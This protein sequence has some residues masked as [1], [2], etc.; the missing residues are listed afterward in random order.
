MM[1][2]DVKKRVVLCRCGARI[3]YFEDFSGKYVVCGRCGEYV[4]LH[5]GR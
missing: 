1:S 4:P 5:G 3:T 2:G